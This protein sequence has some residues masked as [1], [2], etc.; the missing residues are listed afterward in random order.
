MHVGTVELPLS[1][2]AELISVLAAAGI[3]RVDQNVKIGVAPGEIAVMGLIE[4]GSRRSVTVQSQHFDCKRDEA[5]AR[6]HLWRS[7]TAA[8]DR[9]AV[10]LKASVFTTGWLGLLRSRRLGIDIVALL[11][12]WQGERQSLAGTHNG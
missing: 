12:Q 5:E 9:E 7:Y 11:K 10:P 2:R 8:D 4:P 1:I 3:E 6:I